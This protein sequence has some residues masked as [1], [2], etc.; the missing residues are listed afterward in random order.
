MYILFLLGRIAL[1][2]VFIVSGVLKLMDIAGSA[3]ALQAK[4]TVP[5]AIASAA[6][7]A[8]TATGLTIYQMLV[9]AGSALEIILALLLIFNLGTRFCSIV[10]LIFLA[11]VT[12]YSYN[13]LSLTGDALSIV[14]RNVSI[15]GA[16]LLLFVIGPWRP[17][18]FDEDDDY[19]H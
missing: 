13:L 14:L 17:E 15:M 7:G 6:A 16:L 18:A 19:G 3:V 2:A 12:F 1:V 10:L 8:E 5:A 4:F 11:V 9:I